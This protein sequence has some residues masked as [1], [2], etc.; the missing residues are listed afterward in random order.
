MEIT[1]EEQYKTA[2]HEYIRMLVKIKNSTPAEMERLREVSQSIME[3][4]LKQPVKYTMDG[5]TTWN[6]IEI[7]P[8]TF[9][10]ED[11]NERT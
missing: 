10:L 6:E 4:H 7:K 2:S 3:Y 9:V 5:G 11:A 1:N 8:F